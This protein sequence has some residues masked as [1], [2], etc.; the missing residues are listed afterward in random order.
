MD[1]VILFE[2]RWLEQITSEKRNVDILSS[3]LRSEKKVNGNESDCCTDNNRC[4]LEEL[5]IRKGIE[6]MC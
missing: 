2:C 6:G 3:C 5:K 1:E 4:T